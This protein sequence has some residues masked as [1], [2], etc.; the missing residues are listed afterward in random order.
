MTE[1]RYITESVSTVRNLMDR[2]GEN[3]IMEGVEV[4]DDAMNTSIETPL[5]GFTNGVNVIVNTAMG[6]VVKQYHEIYINYDITG[7]G[8][9]A[10][11]KMFMG[12]QKDLMLNKCRRYDSRKNDIACK[13]LNN[14]GDIHLTQTIRI[15]NDGEIR[16]AHSVYNTLDAA[17][18][19]NM[20]MSWEDVKAQIT[21]SGRTKLIN[22]NSIEGQGIL[23][24]FLQKAAKLWKD[25]KAAINGLFGKEPEI[26]DEEGNTVN[27]VLDPKITYGHELSALNKALIIAQ[28]EEYGV[29]T[30]KFVCKAE[31]I[32][33]KRPYGFERKFK[34]GIEIHPY[35]IRAINSRPATISTLMKQFGPEDQAKIK[36]NPQMA[37]EIALQNGDHGSGFLN[38]TTN[39]MWVI[40]Y[41][42][43][44]TEPVNPEEDVFAETYGYADNIAGIANDKVNGLN[45]GPET[46][47]IG[48]VDAS[49]DGINTGNEELPNN[50]VTKTPYVEEITI[51]KK[52]ADAMGLSRSYRDVKIKDLKTRLSFMVQNLCILVISKMNPR[53]GQQECLTHASFARDIILDALGVEHTKL[54]GL[55]NDEIGQ[56]A[57]DKI[58]EYLPSGGDV[59][60]GV[61]LVGESFLGRC[62]ANAING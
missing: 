61:G 58:M 18:G 11:I 44:E 55:V 46:E 43:D 4:V 50:K 33:G 9:D 48:D 25:A 42:I 36:E 2:M 8:R 26:K 34:D 19:G 7:V 15:L 17:S 13:Q 16:R 30:P 54:N 60:G 29:P 41:D 38:T 35:Y 37:F 14:S 31:M 1:K 45:D 56:A 10:F 39:F 62:L 40:Y 6:K 21:I 32:T 28:A 3:L 57:A 49:T 5:E 53:F 47:E 59:A 52:A 20:N 51:V 27:A 23:K 24:G 22:T 12:L